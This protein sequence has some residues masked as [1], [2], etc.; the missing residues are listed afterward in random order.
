MIATASH[1]WTSWLTS[2]V[3][4]IAHGI[5]TDGAY[6][7][8][9]ILADALQDAG[10]DDAA[11]T[12]GLQARP[13]D[14]AGFVG[15]LLTGKPERIK[16]AAL[17][18]ELAAG[19]GCEWKS[20]RKNAAGYVDCEEWNDLMGDGR[21]M[22]W[23]EP[24]R[25]RVEI[26]TRL[27]ELRAAHLGPCP[28]CGDRKKVRKKLVVDGL[29]VTGVFDATDCPTCVLATRDRWDREPC[30]ECK[31]TPPEF[32]NQRGE[33]T[34]RACPTCLHTGDLFLA[35][36]ETAPGERPEGDVRVNRPIR[37]DRGR[38]Y[39][40][41][42]LAEIAGEKTCRYIVRAE[43]ALWI[44]QGGSHTIRNENGGQRVLDCPRCKGTGRIHTPTPWTR[45][46]LTARPDCGIAVEG[47]EPFEY[48]GRF[49]FPG[50]GTPERR[51]LADIMIEAAKQNDT[52]FF[53]ASPTAARHAL[54]AAVTRRMTGLVLGADAMTL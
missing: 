24:C 17:E 54:D 44:C 49:G 18:C 46:L 50:D 31:G 21:V 47:V 33:G 16:F 36:L 1:P 37:T 42:T 39:V 23:C 41:A 5:H 48:E 53:A 11:T 3:V 20:K 30:P 19:L 2:T 26:R 43:G 14:Y 51:W 4:C 40:G 9:P 8:C 15:C 12:D 45:A 27:A 7:R 28:T 6:D 35:Y 29:N 34:F 38:I 52:K 22:T 10:C 25:R 32:P 13:A